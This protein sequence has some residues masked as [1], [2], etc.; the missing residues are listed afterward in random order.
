MLMVETNYFHKL[1]VIEIVGLF[2]CFANIV[3]SDDF[4]V[5]YPNTSSEVLN[6]TT[7]RIVTLLDEF[8]D[9]ELLHHVNSGSCYE[10]CFDIQQAVMDWCRASNETDCKRVLDEL[11]NV[12][13]VFLGEFIK[14]LLKINNVT[15]EVERAAQLT[16]NIVLLEKLNHIPS[17]TLKYVATTQ[18][19]YV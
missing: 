14:A 5:H 8:H 12:S 15:A 11:K 4:K 7:T 13:N 3:V 16:Q 10:R 9:M 17:V 2:A 18:S 1:S 6:K 19:L